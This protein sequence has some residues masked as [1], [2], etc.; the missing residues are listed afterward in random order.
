MKLIVSPSSN[1][2]TLLMNFNVNYIIQIGLIKL[3]RFAPKSNTMV[4]IECI[5]QYELK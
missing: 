3:L 2:S 4:K 5:V 1:I